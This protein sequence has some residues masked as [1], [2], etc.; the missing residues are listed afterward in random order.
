MAQQSTK[1]WFAVGI[2]LIIAGGA[3]YGLLAILGIGLAIGE[4]SSEAGAPFLFVLAIPGLIALGFLVLLAKVIVDRIGNA[5]D[6]HYSKTV[7]K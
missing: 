3:V 7:D 6:D 1:G 2:G 4:V 5:E